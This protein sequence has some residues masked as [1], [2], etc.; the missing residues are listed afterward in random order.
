MLVINERAVMPR[1]EQR[2]LDWMRTWTGQ[3]VIVGLAISGCRVPDREGDAR[4]A[5]LVVITPRAVLVIEVE[6]TVPDATTGVLSVRPDGRWRL[7]GLRGTRSR[8]PPTTTPCLI[9]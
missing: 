6:G 9:R 5:D 1:S 3:Y 4:E 8:C 7:S 2:V